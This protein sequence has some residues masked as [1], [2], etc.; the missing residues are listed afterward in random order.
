MT[1]IMDKA[2]DANSSHG[3]HG[4]TR[5]REYLI[6]QLSSIRKTIIDN[7]QNT[8]LFGLKERHVAGQPYKNKYLQD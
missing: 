2:S 7:S 3:S 1:T 4:S 6:R 5:I 8:I